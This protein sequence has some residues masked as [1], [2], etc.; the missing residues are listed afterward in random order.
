MYQPLIEHTNQSS[1]Q[2]IQQ[3]ISIL[4]D[5]FSTP[6]SP[7]SPHIVT[8]WF[9]FLPAVYGRNK[10]LDATIRS[11][12][13]H[14]LGNATGNRQ[15]IQ[16]GQSAYVEALHRLQRSLS[17]PIECVSSDIFCAVILSCLYEVRYCTRSL[18]DTPCQSF[19]PK[20]AFLQHTR[21]WILDEACQGAEP[22]SW[23]PRTWL[24]PK[25]IDSILLKASRGIIVCTGIPCTL[26]VLAW[27]LDRSW[28][29]YFPVKNAS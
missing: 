12:T 22:I 11:F 6:S 29:P 26:A 4:I 9:G 8:R 23:I 25:R 28:I 17:N 10:T 14:H 1:L 21:F 5:S 19:W 13:A 16:Y 27:H 15:V 18:L 2:H 24:L 20:C 3:S 7:A